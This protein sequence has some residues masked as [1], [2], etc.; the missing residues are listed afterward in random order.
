ML[1]SKPA[2]IEAALEE[3]MPFYCEH[4]D[5]ILNLGHGL[6]PDIPFKM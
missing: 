6:L 3:L 5:Y 2:D 1:Y 4:S